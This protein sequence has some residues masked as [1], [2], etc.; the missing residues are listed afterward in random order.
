MIDSLKGEIIVRRPPLLV[1]DVHGVGYGVQM[2]TMFFDALPREG[3]VKILT[4]MLVREDDQQ[5]FGFISEFDRALFRA[6]IKVSG[7]GPRIALAALSGIDGNTM[8]RYIIDRQ[9]DK[10]MR[11]PGIGRKTAERVILELEGKM[12]E[13][14]AQF[15]R[16]TAASTNRTDE[17]MEALTV[18][19][20]KEADARRM[21]KKVDMNQDASV[22][23]I[24]RSALKVGA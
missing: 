17:A 21:I 8:M 5:L 11:V 9:P 3:T 2:P 22:G 7:I 14:A 23:D 13:M 18:L 4:H 24:I 20:Y 6:L 1:L 19:G 15:G 16:E 12:A 10:L